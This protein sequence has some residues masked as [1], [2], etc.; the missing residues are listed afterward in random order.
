LKWQNQWYIQTRMPFGWS[1]SPYYW[2]IVAT[3]L[4]QKLR[5]MG[6]TVMIYVDD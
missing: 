2:N 1:L 4:A 6:I 5:T 3:T